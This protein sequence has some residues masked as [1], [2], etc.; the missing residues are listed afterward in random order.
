MSIPTYKVLRTKRRAKIIS[1]CSVEGLKISSSEIIPSKKYSLQYGQRV[2]VQAVSTDGKWLLVHKCQNDDGPN[3]IQQESTKKNDD[4]ALLCPSVNVNF[5][6]EMTNM[7]S[8]QRQRSSSTAVIEGSRGIGSNY[9]L[10]TS[11][12][13]TKEETSTP[14][15]QQKEESSIPKRSST[16]KPEPKEAKPYL[17]NSGNTNEYE[18]IAANDNEMGGDH[19]ENTEEQCESQSSSSMDGQDSQSERDSQSE[20]S[21]KHLDSA[22]QNV[23]TLQSRRDSEEEPEIITDMYGFRMMNERENDD[24]PD[25]LSTYSSN[26]TT[27]T[28]NSNITTTQGGGGSEPHH[29]SQVRASFPGDLFLDTNDNHLNGSTSASLVGGLGSRHSL[30][31]KSS[32]SRTSKANTSTTTAKTVFKNFRNFNLGGG[33]KND[34]NCS[35]RNSTGKKKKKNKVLN[36]HS[37]DSQE[38][39]T[40]STSEENTG[41]LSNHRSTRSSKS[42]GVP[43]WKKRGSFTKFKLPVSL[44]SKSSTASMSTS[45]SAAKMRSNTTVN[46]NSPMKDDME[47]DSTVKDLQ[48]QGT[49]LDKG[50]NLSPKSRNQ[51][52]ENSEA[53]STSSINGDGNETYHAPTPVQRHSHFR[54]KKRRENTTPSQY[55]A[56]VSTLASSTRSTGNN[57]MFYYSST[58]RKSKQPQERHNNRTI[59][60]H[61][62]DGGDIFFPP[63]DDETTQEEDEE[64]NIKRKNN[65]TTKEREKDVMAEYE[66][67]RQRWKDFFASHGHELIRNFNGRHKDP[68]KDPFDQDIAESIVQRWKRKKAKHSK[69]LSKKQLRK[70]QRQ[71]AAATTL[72]L[73]QK[74]SGHLGNNF[75]GNK[76]IS[77]RP[78]EK[79]KKNKNNE[80]MMDGGC[81]VEGEARIHHQR[82]YSS[83]N[84]SYTMTSSPA[85]RSRDIISN[86]PEEEKRK[87]L[88]NDN[89]EKTNIGENTNVRSGQKNVGDASGGGRPKKKRYFSFSKFFQKKSSSDNKEISIDHE[90][91]VNDNLSTTTFAS[92]RSQFGSIRKSKKQGHST[93]KTT[94]ISRPT[95]SCT[96][97]STPPCTFTPPC[98]STPPCTSITDPQVSSDKSDSTTKNTMINDQSAIQQ[99]QQINSNLNANHVN[100]NINAER[101]KQIKQ[102]QS[103]FTHL[104]RKGI[105]PEMRGGIW[106]LCSGAQYNA[107]RV[108]RNRILREEKRKLRMKDDNDDDR[109]REEEEEEVPLKELTYEEL[110][111]DPRIDRSSNVAA[112]IERD[113]KRTFPTNVK[114]SR[115]R[116]GGGEKPSVMTKKKINSENNNHFR[117]TTSSSNNAPDDEDK[118]TTNVRNQKNES[119]DSNEVEEREEE[120]E[121]AE[122]LVQLRQVLLAYATRNPAVGYCQSMN[123]IT[124]MLLLHM[125]AR[126]AFWVL[127][128][129]V[130]DILPEYYSKTMS[131]IHTDSR[132]FT[133]LLQEKISKVYN[134]V[135]SPASSKGSDGKLYR[136]TL[137]GMSA[138]FISTLIFHPVDLVKVRLQVSQASTA[139]SNSQSKSQGISSKKVSSSTN[140]TG[141]GMDTK[142]TAVRSTMNDLAAPNYRS[143]LH[144]IQSILRDE[145]P[146]SFYQGITPALVGNAV[147]WGLYFF[148]Y[149]QA[150]TRRRKRLANTN[151]SFISGINSSSPPRLSWDQHLLSGCEAGALTTLMT[152]PI[153]LVK[154]RLQLQVGTPGEKK[155]NPNVKNKS[156]TRLYTGMFDAFRRIIAEEGVFALYKGITPALLLVSH[157]AIQFMAYEELKGYAANSWRKGQDLKAFDLEPMILGGVSKVIASVATYPYQVIKSRVQMR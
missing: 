32:S 103:Q 142:K 12:D 16:S 69:L 4:F 2:I 115:M 1:S 145:G 109:E 84:D 15:Q 28:T 30:S 152:N 22:K 95:T 3:N 64:E 42:F 75:S 78:N 26:I 146:K 136:H 68:V 71:V 57:N 126:E 56:G 58:K 13:K 147:S 120:E 79:M 132:V 39:E 35:I 157:G 65:N 70:E 86:N 106:Y 141:T 44:R 104:I 137:S 17:L 148:F 156:S 53:D 88:G 21:A 54:K 153:W 90:D 102:L 96:G 49:N 140:N 62:G 51:Y 118:S 25:W 81:H 92:A 151:N 72:S 29:S 33:K 24:D 105:P 131:G 133:M 94:D 8:F 107:E 112:E 110:I 80:E 130:E 52:N 122:G 36:N 85:G 45:S 41:V 138:G 127:T 150:K 123:F 23:K 66:K 40:S 89:M 100:P 61:R 149:E 135:S 101:R 10:K 139:A 37:T 31:M 50:T 63:D 117:S 55:R 114:F 91:N 76:K 5:E 77:G 43:F 73:I 60:N 34:T 108:E 99:Q 125:E 11:K 47:G 134:H 116:G 93:T 111:N 154:T 59:N 67:A 38:L 124:A 7:D 18:N 82:D 9:V 98:I 113:L 6:L 46:K 143:S 129:L 20:D 48:D 144:A 128:A 14:P 19:Y 87:I 155:A 119:T 27:N 74:S 83:G 121:E 97:T